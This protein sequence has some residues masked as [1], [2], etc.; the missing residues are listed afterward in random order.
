MARTKQTQRN[1]AKKRV[2]K[3][4]PHPFEKTVDVGTRSFR[5]FEVI[6]KIAKGAFG[7]VYKGKAQNGEF[8]AM[9]FVDLNDEATHKG[10]VLEFE[11]A[12]MLSSCGVGPKVLGYWRIP[13][14]DMALLVTDL[15]STTLEGYLHDNKIKKPSKKIM[16]KLQK[17]LQGMH[18]TDHVHLD[19]HSGNVLLRLN[20]KNKVVDVALA[21]FG[22]ATHKKGFAEWQLKEAI[23][24]W[25]LDSSNDPVNLDWQM[26]EKIKQGKL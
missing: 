23:K 15:W 4:F 6:K 25:K 12:N 11:L 13:S 18:D 20:E 3:V 8:C 24:K 9:K 1:E 14:V 17:Q 21:D 5:G 19:L 2:R 10:V 26:F 22:K 16:K 7:R